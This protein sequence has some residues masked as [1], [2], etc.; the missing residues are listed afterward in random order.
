MSTFTGPSLSVTAVYVLGL[1]A[2]FPL[3]R[4]TRGPVAMIV[5]FGLVAAL[6]VEGARYALVAEDVALSKRLLTALALGLPLVALVVRRWATDSDDAWFAR[7]ARRVVVVALS[8]AVPLLAA[9][10]LGARHAEPSAYAR[11]QRVLGYNP[12]EALLFEGVGFD[13]T[14][15]ARS[16]WTAFQSAR[17]EVAPEIRAEVERACGRFGASDPERACSCADELLSTR[18]R[19]LERQRDDFR[20]L[21]LFSALPWAIAALFSWRGRREQPEVHAFSTE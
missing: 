13:R 9:A 16:G 12:L 14:A 21:G 2:T 20:A 10:A 17:S 7:H 19:T 15:H 5:A 8:V 18:Y 1:A 3:H 11:A 4:T 6:S